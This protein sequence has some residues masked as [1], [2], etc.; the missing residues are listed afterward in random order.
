MY[1]QKKPYLHYLKVDLQV[2]FSAEWQMFP[3]VKCVN[4]WTSLGKKIHQFRFWFLDFPNTAEVNEVC[5]NQVMRLKTVKN[6]RALMSSGGA[7]RLG[8]HFCCLCW[9]QS[10]SGV[11]LFLKDSSRSGFQLYFAICCP[12]FASLVEAGLL[13]LLTLPKTLQNNSLVK[14]WALIGFNSRPVNN[15]L[16]WCRILNNSSFYLKILSLI[17][18]IWRQK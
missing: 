12:L 14:N 8:L 13:V 9:F 16:K 11:S 7:L 1:E 6:A 18:C 10:C 17:C 15:I 2:E 4:M 5:Q 3:T